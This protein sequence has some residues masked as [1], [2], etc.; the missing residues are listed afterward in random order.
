MCKVTGVNVTIKPKTIGIHQILSKMQ[1]TVIVDFLFTSGWV[2]RLI[3][4]HVYLNIVC[5]P[6]FFNLILVVDLNEI[7]VCVCNLIVNL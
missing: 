6:K 5:V 1:F 4:G 7:F 2:E 3:S